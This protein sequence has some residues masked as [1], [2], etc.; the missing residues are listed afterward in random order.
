[1][2]QPDLKATLQQFMDAIWNAGNY[3]A[4]P[5]YVSEQYTVKH[6]P[7]DAWEGQTLDHATFIE[8]VR[9]SRNAFPDLNFDIQQMVA[10]GQRV[11]A[12][13]V[14]SGTHNGD[15]TDLPATGRPFRISG[16]TIYDFDAYG[17]VS[18]HTQ[19]YDRLGFLA[20]LGVLGM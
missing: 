16:M 10:E 1:M 5:T 8:R 14:M 9:Y 15:L 6:D 7:G 3:D 11:V 2:T 18:G 13:W 4:V 17:K 19:A 20:Q 12:F